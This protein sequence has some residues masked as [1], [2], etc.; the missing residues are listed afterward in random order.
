MKASGLYDVVAQKNNI[1]HRGLP[2]LFRQCKEMK[3]PKAKFEQRGDG[4]K[5]TI[6]RSIGVNTNDTNDTNDEL[7]VALE[8]AVLTVMVMLEKET[9][10]TQQM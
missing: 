7:I 4:I 10:I 6:Y 3:L 1:D 9:N 2:R 8:D 5:V